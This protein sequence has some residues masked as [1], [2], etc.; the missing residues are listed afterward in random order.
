MLQEQR[1]TFKKN[2][3]SIFYKFYIMPFIRNL[4]QTLHG[5]QE[6]TLSAPE[7][8]E[9]TGTWRARYGN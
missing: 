1:N 8:K 4:M 3:Y 9:L 5:P 2:I 6:M 7:P